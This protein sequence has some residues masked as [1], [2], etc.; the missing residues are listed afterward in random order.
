MILGQGAPRITLTQK[1]CSP[2]TV[3]TYQPRVRGAQ[4]HGLRPLA[5]VGGRL[6]QVRDEVSA[7]TTTTTTTAT[8]AGNSTRSARH[9][10]A[11]AHA[12]AHAHAD[13]GRPAPHGEMRLQLLGFLRLRLR[14]PL[15][16]L[17]TF[18]RREG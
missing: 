14:Q 3:H 13:T 16:L 18:Q 12:H 17:R 11:H 15:R 10:S 8:A 4:G 2:Q 6:G 5:C 1:K 7:L 9:A